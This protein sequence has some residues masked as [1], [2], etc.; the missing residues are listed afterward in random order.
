MGTAVYHSAIRIINAT[1]KSIYTGN[2]VLTWGKF[3]DGID[4]RTEIP[5]HDLE[6]KEIQDKD[7]WVYVCRRPDIADGEEGSIDLVD[8]DGKRIATLTWDAPWQDTRPN[9]FD[10]INKASGY[11]VVADGW[12][13]EGWEFGTARVQVTSVEE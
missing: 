10:V 7:F 8:G 12:L 4:K 1:G 11:S 6:G 9:S 13:R 2:V 3:F 5:P